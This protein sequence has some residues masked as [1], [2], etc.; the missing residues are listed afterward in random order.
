MSGDRYYIT[1]QHATYYLTFTVVDWIDIFTRP[2]YKYIITDSLN[3]CIE[4]KGWEVNAWVLMTNHL[5][6]VVR[7]RPPF[8][9]SDVIRDFKKFTSKKIVKAVQE[10]P[11]SRREWLLHKFNYH[12]ITTGRAKE[13]KVWKDDN[14][15]IHLDG[16][17]LIKQKIDYIHNNP[18]TAAIVSDP[19]DYIFS[20][21]SV[22]A[23]SK[24]A[25]VKLV[26]YDEGVGV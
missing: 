2:D 7:T 9:M 11:E 6:L 5:H 16:S 26:C 22:Y 1:D 13:Y 25:L 17:N 20:S 10:L 14:H 19:Q 15:A 18:V 4:N 21:A 3:Y 8:R 12:A 23:G 24:Q